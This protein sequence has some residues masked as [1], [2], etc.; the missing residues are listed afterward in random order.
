[1]ALTGLQR[2]I[3]DLV[4]EDSFALTEVVSR[5]RRQGPG[6]SDRDATSMV[7]AAVRE[8]LESGMVRLTEMESP[9]SGERD[10]DDRAAHV[11]LDDDLAWV[12]SPITRRHVRV[13]ATSKG[14]EAFY[15]G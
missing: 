9:Q 6:P 13:V 15:A 12:D 14:Q 10:L 8:L 3:L 2:A 7:K 11:A 5:V 1:M 4:V